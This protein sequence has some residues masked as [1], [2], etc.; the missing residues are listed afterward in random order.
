MFLFLQTYNV[1]QVFNP[2]AV[3]IMAWLVST[4]GIVFDLLIFFILTKLF[5]SLQVV[6]RYTKVWLFLSLLA[7]LYGIYQQMFGYTDFEWRDIYSTPGKIYLIQNWGILRK[8]S[9]MSDVAALVFAWPIV[10]YSV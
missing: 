1:L 7:A 3:S 2:N 4:R 9:F 6:V 5:T 10:Q 8:F